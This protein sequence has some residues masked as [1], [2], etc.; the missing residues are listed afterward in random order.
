MDMTLTTI[1]SIPAILAVVNLVKG[2]G[3][4]AK[5]APLV[6]VTIGITFAVAQGYFGDTLL[7]RNVSEG[8]LLGLAASGFY[9]MAKRKG[10][11][12][13]DEGDE[14]GGDSYVPARAISAD[15]Q[16]DRIGFASKMR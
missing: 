6:A 4:P 16:G 3:V 5:V 9:D 11:T 7:Y 15:A 2:L 14:D 13:D 1:V 10:S 12:Q 8:L